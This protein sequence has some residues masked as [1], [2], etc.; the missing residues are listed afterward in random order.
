M[1]PINL[2]RADS[3]AMYVVWEKGKRKTL[4]AHKKNRRDF[5]VRDGSGYHPAAMALANQSLTAFASTAHYWLS[6]QPA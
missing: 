1:I 6:R 4:E 3:E 5:R 2:K